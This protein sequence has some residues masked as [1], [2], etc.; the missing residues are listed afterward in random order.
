MT[1]EEIVW[2]YEQR[3]ENAIAETSKK[4]GAYCFEI[5]KNILRSPLDAEES[6]S[7]TYLAAWN[8]IPPQRPGILSAFLGKITRNIAIDRWRREKAAK[9]GGG[10]MTLALEELRECVSGTEGPEDRTLE[11]ERLRAIQRFLE[12]LS[13]VERKTFLCRYWYLETSAE[14]GKKF[15]MTPVRVRAMLSRTRKKLRAYLEKEGLL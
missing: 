5:A 14:I 12:R 6:V 13:P 4:Y 7:D 9:R 11:N 2:L 1:D 10:E 15:G 8:S 3:A